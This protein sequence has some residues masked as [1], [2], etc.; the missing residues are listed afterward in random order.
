MCTYLIL[1]HIGQIKEHP[2]VC[3][4]YESLVRIREENS[5]IP[6]TQEETRDTRNDV[7]TESRI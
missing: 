6:S 4:N 1:Q 2:N 5:G 7:E 3:I